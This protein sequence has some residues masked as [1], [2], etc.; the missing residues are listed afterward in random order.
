MNPFTEVAKQSRE[1]TNNALAG[2]ISSLV[3]FPKKKVE[4]LLP[5]KRDKEEFVKLMAKVK[6][7]TDMDE[8]L[9]YLETNVKAVGK[10]IIQV[11]RGLT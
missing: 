10:V 11:L 8:K 5:E 2:K 1:S 7:E 3:S 9:A 4:R 6:D